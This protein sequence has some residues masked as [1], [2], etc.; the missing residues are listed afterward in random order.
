MHFRK[1]LFYFFYVFFLTCLFTKPSLSLTIPKGYPECAP[2]DIDEKKTFCP[3]EGRL[4][5]KL[6]I[7]DFTTKLQ[8]FQTDSI[9]DSAL[10]IS[11]IEDTKPYHKISFVRIDHKSASEQKAFFVTCRMKTGIGKFKETLEGT[12]RDCEGKKRIQKYFNEF[13]IKLALATGDFALIGEEN[14]T[15]DTLAEKLALQVINIH[16]SN[17]VEFTEQEIKD[18]IDEYKKEVNKLRFFPI[19]HVEPKG[20]YIYETIIEVLRTSSFDF[21]NKYPE[22]ELIIASDLVQISDKINL[23]HK[24]GYC[25]LKILTTEEKRYC[26]TFDGLLKNKTTRDYLEATKLNKEQLENLKVKVLFLNHNYSCETSPKAAKSLQLLWDELFSYQGIDN[27]EWEW[28]LDP[29]VKPTC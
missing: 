22:R 7:V 21:T 1:Y 3:L 13:K 25:K 15:Y 19:R 6:I 16:I 9:I 28:Q 12:N 27:V 20:S 5:H 8:K 17:G 4:G 2:K 10:G 18:Y 26:G 14:E 29:N 11:L 24:T 23:S